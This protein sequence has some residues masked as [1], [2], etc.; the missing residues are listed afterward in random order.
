ML[1]LKKYN[2]V[3]KV[4]SGNSFPL[5]NLI[6]IPLKGTPKFL[7]SHSLLNKCNSWSSGYLINQTSRSSSYPNLFQSPK[8]YLLAKSFPFPNI[9]RKEVFPVTSVA[10]LVHQPSCSIILF[11]LKKLKN[12]CINKLEHHLE[13]LHEALFKCSC[14]KSKNDTL[15]FGIIKGS[16]FHLLFLSCIPVSLW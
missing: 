16:F 3:L 8:F 4:I 1:K 5:Q 9:Y 11:V 15:D 13:S 10:W 7:S 12:D 2:M 14:S 6:S